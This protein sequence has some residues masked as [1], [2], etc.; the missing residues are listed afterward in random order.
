MARGPPKCHSKRSQKAAQ[1]PMF[2]RSRSFGSPEIVHVRTAPR[3][4]IKCWRSVSGTA[5]ARRL[6]SHSCRPRPQFGA[7]Q[8]GYGDCGTNLRAVG[9]AG[10][11]GGRRGRLLVLRGRTGTRDRDLGERRSP[12]QAPQRPTVKKAGVVDVTRLAWILSSVSSGSSLA[13]TRL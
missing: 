1:A 11:G 5:C 2:G 7:M 4:A 6:G 12:A 8:F 3:L 10:G 9:G 13:S